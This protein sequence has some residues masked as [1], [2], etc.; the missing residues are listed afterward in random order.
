MSHLPAGTDSGRSD[1]VT[2][3]WGALPSSLQQERLQVTVGSATGCLP[4]WADSGS[5]RD[6]CWG[7]PTF[8]KVRGQHPRDQRVPDRGLKPGG[9]VSFPPG[10]SD[11]HRCVTGETRRVNSLGRPGYFKENVELLDVF[12][13]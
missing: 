6:C 13:K 9:C 2:I 5:K 12:P 11:R 4:F 1:E 10:F 8:P 7:P 3:R